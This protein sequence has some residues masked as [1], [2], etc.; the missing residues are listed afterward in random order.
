MK[1]QTIL[2]RHTTTGE[3][4]I[5]RT[6]GDTIAARQW[7]DSSQ[8]AAYLD[9]EADLEDNHLEEH[10]LEDPEPWHPAQWRTLKG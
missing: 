1:R 9:P 5:L 3:V 8:V 6:E 2:A 4:A 10:Q 7:L